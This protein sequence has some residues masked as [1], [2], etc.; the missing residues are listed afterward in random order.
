MIDYRLRLKPDYKLIKEFIDEGATVLDLGCGD[1]TLLEALTKDKKVKGI[2]V[3][4]HPEGLDEAMG[5]GLSVLQLDLNKGLKSFKD[6]SFDYVVLNMTLQAMWDPLLVIQEMVRVGKAAIVGF[7]NFGH[8]KL[9][10]R[11][12]ATE[13]MPKTKVL[14]YEWY[15]TPNIRLMT[16]NDFKALCLENG[17][18]I[19]KDKYLNAAGAEIY[20]PLIRWRAVEGIFLIE[21]KA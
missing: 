17:I 2:G 9:L 7:P 6:K 16:I 3:D 12:L 8:W 14:P 18:K 11:L 1:G 21:E 15:D 13:R 5:R 10:F 20:R 19:V 4:I